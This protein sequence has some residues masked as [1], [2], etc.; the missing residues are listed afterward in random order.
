MI[1]QISVGENVCYFKETSSSMDPNSAIVKLSASVQSSEPF[2]EID[3]KLSESMVTPNV[4]GT[5][6]LVTAF[7]DVNTAELSEQKHEKRSGIPKADDASERKCP[8]IVCMDPP[9]RS[10]RKSLLLQN[11]VNPSIRNAGRTAAKRGTLD[12]NN[13]NIIRR[14]RT[15]SRK[16]TRSSVWTSLGNDIQTSEHGEGAEVVKSDQRKSRRAKR[17][18]KSEKHDNNQAVQNLQTSMAKNRICL[19]VKFGQRSLMDVLPLIENGNGTYS[20]TSK[21]P[22]RVPESICDQFEDEMNKITGL[23]GINASLDSSFTSSDAS[24]TNMGPAGKNVDESPTEKYLE[25]HN[26]SPTL[27]EVGKLGTPV[28]DRCSNPGTSPDSEV[29]NLIPDA[30]ISLKG[31]DNLHGLMSTQASGA[32]EDFASF[33]IVENCHIK[34]KKKDRLVK[35]ADCSVKATFPSSEIIN[36]EQ[37]LGQFTLGEF[38]G[39]GSYSDR[40]DTYILTTSKNASGSVSST[41]LCPG[42]P[43]PLSKVDDF[44][45]SSASPMLEHSVV[46]N[47]CSSLDT[48]SPDLQMPEKSLSSTEKLKPSKRGKSKWVGK[49]QSE[50][51]NSSSR[52]NS[53]KTKVNKGKKSGKCEVKN[54]PHGVQGLTEL[55]N[56]PEP[57]NQTSSQL[58]QIGSGIKISCL[59]TSNQTEGHTESMSL[60]NAWVQCDDCQKWRRIPAVL[61]DQI[62]ETNCKW[63]CKDNM[64]KDFAD[65]SIPQEKSNSAINAELEIS[66]V[67]GDEDAS[68]ASLNHNCSGKK[69]TVDQSSSWT[70]I[71]SNLFLQRAHKSQTIDEVMVCHCKPPSDGQMGCGDGCLNR[72]LNIECVQGT[73]PCGEL[74]SNQQF[75]KRN[76]AKLKWF[77][78][79]KKG[80]GL[81]LLEDVSEGRFLIEY[82]GEVLGMQAYEGRQREYA[83]KGHR[84]FYFMTLNGS[85]VIDACAKG[86]LGRFINHSCDPNCSTEKWMVNGEVCIGLFALRDIKKGEEVTFDYN[87]VRVFGAAAKRCVCGSPQCR[88]YIGG[89]TLNAEVIVQDDSDDEYPEPVVVCEDVDMHDELNYIKS[90]ANSFSGLEMR[91][92]DEASEYNDILVGHGS[93]HTP[94]SVKTKNGDITCPESFETNKS[95]AAIECLNTTLRSGELLDSSASSAVRVE[96]SVTLEGSGGLQFSGAKEEGSE[97]EKVVENSVS[98]VELEVTSSPATLSKPLK[99]SKSGCVGGKA[100]GT[101]SCPLVKASRLS[102]SVKKAKSK[103]TKAPLEIGNRSKL[104]EHK[105][106]KPPEGSLNARFE[107]VEEKLNEL[108]D[109]EGGISKRKD[110]SRCYLKLLLLT[111]ASGGSGN[112]ETIQ[113]NRELSMILDALLKTKSRTVLVDIINKNGLQMLHNIMKRYR[114]EFNK[115]PILRKLLKV[116]EYLAMREILA[117][118]HI[119]GGPSRPGVESF[120]DSILTLTEHIDKQVHQI[121][122][123]FRDRWIPRALRKGCFMDKDDGR[124]AFHS[125]STVGSNTADACAVDG[126]TVSCSGLGVSNGTKTRKRKSRWDQEAEPKDDCEQDKDD[127]P[128]PGYEFPPGFSAP[129]NNP[130][131]LCTSKPVTGH[132]QQ[133]FISHLPVSFGIPFNVVQQFGTPQIGTSEVWA[134]A[135][136]IPFQPFP[137]LPTCSRGRMDNVPPLP[138]PQ[139]SHQ[140]AQTPPPQC[141]KIDPMPSQN[142]FQEYPC[143]TQNPTGRTSGANLPPEVATGEQ[144]HQRPNGSF[145]LGRRYFRQQKWSG[146][147]PPPPWLRMRNGWGYA[148]NNPKNV[149]CNVGVGS[150]ATDFR[151]SHGPEDV[152][153]VREEGSGTGPTFSQN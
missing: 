148:G 30:H 13:L 139:L 39:D 72:M 137:P 52:A 70:L 14:K 48:H 128:P 123:S 77:K 95:A 38:I 114:R 1:S 24:V 85:E 94:C 93:V 136:G 126:S 119:N 146:S 18:Q 6:V 105:V 84:H 78:C 12:I 104:P 88:G 102:S 91:T 32:S 115:I 5:D 17:G 22:V 51:V 42:E 46:V 47:L 15:S 142:C 35:T 140:P 100:E 56:D 87:Y 113:S 127:A 74:C 10:A 92:V 106:K 55:G 144:S 107:A 82:V 75:Q 66:D 60:R 61:A 147:K 101:K 90:S 27:A 8:D 131:E 145:N 151:S 65:C 11:Q 99:K 44:G 110:A 54:K 37:P 49:N 143:H 69:S 45:G 141:H 73:C 121:A 108:L 58:G 19:K 57:E 67:S 43:E 2:S 25:S 16:P 122:R 34:G 76:Y 138:S 29:I 103:S 53:S 33:G 20:S 64:D 150:V 133:T 153:M 62:E 129:I 41:E 4:S 50:I 135:P 109:P 86:N 118:E 120:R 117:F 68:H 124:T 111:A 96:T 3:D 81:Q 134:V 23:N 21:E 89:D 125:H 9:R 116:L 28:D 80:Y 31:L 79:G 130:K 71:K 63:I 149:M 152:G 83:S 59:G 36:N 26:E 98:P 97:G 132:C 40:A 112:S 7:D